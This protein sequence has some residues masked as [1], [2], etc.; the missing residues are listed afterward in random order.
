MTRKSI[1]IAVVFLIIAV[2]LAS[3][4]LVVTSIQTIGSTEFG[5]K[6]DSIK[7]HLQKE[8]FYEGLYLGQPGF[9]IIKFS[10]VFR[11]M[12]FQ[13]FHCLN[14]DEIEIKLILS[15]QYRVR[16]EYLYNVTLLFKDQEGLD[17]MVEYIAKAAI[18]ESCS[19]FNTSQFQAERG[20]FQ[21]AVKDALI[22]RLETVYT[23][24]TDL[25][26]QNIQRPLEYENA[27]QSKETAREDIDVARQEA[28]KR[29]IIAIN[30]L[31]DIKNAAEIILQKAKSHANVVLIQAEATKKAIM[32]QYE[33]EAKV[34]KNLKIALG[35]SDQDF[36]RYLATRAI[37]SPK[38][39]PVDI[40]IGQSAQ[41]DLQK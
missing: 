37:F 20:Q 33:N 35:F 11:S 24:L 26:M 2:L 8:V 17:E 21:L 25:Q 34:N 16:S 3:V 12:Q 28:P 31:K 30:K 19:M 36:I 39:S 13:D 14:K 9:Q 18:Y 6:Y 5:L 15:F 38:D 7:K 32:Q 41:L 29:K 1:K 4:I 23:D 40:A 22:K 10:A 27:I